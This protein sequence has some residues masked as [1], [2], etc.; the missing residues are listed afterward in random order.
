MHAILICT[1]SSRRYAPRSWCSGMYHKQATN[2][3]TVGR[4]QAC[5]SYIMHSR[6]CG[7]SCFF[8]RYV[9]LHTWTDLHP[10]KIWNDEGFCGW[11]NEW[12]GTMSR[13]C[14]FRA[15]E[16]SS[17]CAEARG[18][19]KH[20]TRLYACCVSRRAYVIEVACRIAKLLRVWIIC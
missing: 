13:Q 17:A 11:R 7:L 14:Q 16:Q 8:E 10:Q 4:R 3:V 5:N 15:I 1:C 2:L 6:S 18:S 19:S 9:A 20:Q 12:L